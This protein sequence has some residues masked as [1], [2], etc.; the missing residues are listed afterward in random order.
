[1][2]NGNYYHNGSTKHHITFTFS[3]K[4]VTQTTMSNIIFKLT[5]HETKSNPAERTMITVHHL[6]EKK[7]LLIT[8][9]KNSLLCDFDVTQN[10]DEGQEV[11][12]RYGRDRGK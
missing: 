12:Y 9:S 5:H 8:T 4:C 1:M 2:G 11:N 10:S 7:R 6:M 3:H